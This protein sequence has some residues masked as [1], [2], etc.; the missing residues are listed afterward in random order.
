LPWGQYQLHYRPGGQQQQQ[1]NQFVQW[2]CADMQQSD[3]L[4]TADQ[5]N[6]LIQP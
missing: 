1:I 6:T 2:F 3:L 5:Q 4:A